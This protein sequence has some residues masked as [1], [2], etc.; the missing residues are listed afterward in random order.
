MSDA[1]LFTLAMALIAAYAGFCAG[2]LIG[3]SDE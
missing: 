2:L 3:A 1:A